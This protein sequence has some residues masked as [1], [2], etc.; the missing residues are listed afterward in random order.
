[1]V[2]QINTTPTGVV[3]PNNTFSN[4]TANLNGSSVKITKVVSSR[5]PLIGNNSQ[6]VIY[7][8]KNT[9]SVNKTNTGKSDANAKPVYFTTSTGNKQ[10]IQSTYLNQQHPTMR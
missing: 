6:N 1:M 2:I 3:G 4:T 8:N 9:I 10:P 7:L 5:P